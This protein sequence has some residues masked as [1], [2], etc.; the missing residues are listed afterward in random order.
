VRGLLLRTS[1]GGSDW[2]TF[3]M[4]SI[5]TT[6]GYGFVTPRIGYATSEDGILRTTDGGRRWR[7][8]EAR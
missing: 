1:D 7:W 8:I 6:P 5:L 2:T 4:P 3:Q